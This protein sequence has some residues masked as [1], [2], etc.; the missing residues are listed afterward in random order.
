MCVSQEPIE[1]ASFSKTRARGPEYN[2]SQ[3]KRY[4][5]PAVPFDLSEGF[6]TFRD[7]DRGN[8][9]PADVTPIFESLR[10]AGGGRDEQELAAVDVV[11]WRGNFAKLLATPWNTRDAW[12][13]EA[14]L[15]HG[16]VVLNVVEPE[17]NL[18]RE[19]NREGREA[20]MC[21]WGF[22]FEEACTGGTF[23]NPVD[24]LDS[25]CTVVRTGVGRHRLVMGGEVDC[26]DGEREG[27]GGY[28]ELKTTRVLDSAPQVARFERDKLLKW[29]AQSFSTGVRRILVGFRDDNGTV[30]KL[31][32][33]ETLKLPGYA[34]RHP[35][36]WD[37][38]TA[39]Q[40]TDRLLTWLRTHL[41]SLPMGSRVRMEYEPRRW[42]GEVRIVAFPAGPDGVPAADVPGGVRNFL[43]P[44][45]RASLARAAALRA[46]GGG[47]SSGGAGGSRGS[48]GGSVGNRSG[49][50]T[51]GGTASAAAAAQEAHKKV[52]F[53][54]G[55]GT[56]SGRSERSANPLGLASPAAAAGKNQ[57]ASTGGPDS[58]DIPGSFGRP[59]M[60]PV[61][62]PNVERMVHWDFGEP[63]PPHGHRRRRRHERSQTPV[64]GARSLERGQ[65]LLQVYHPIVA[66]PGYGDPLKMAAYKAAYAHSL[67]PA[68]LSYL[69]GFSPGDD[70]WLGGADEPGEP[71]DEGKENGATQAAKQDYG[72]DPR[73]F[74]FDPLNPA[75]TPK[76]VDLLSG[77]SGD[78]GQQSSWVSAGV[79]P[80]VSAG[81][82]TH[83]GGGSRA[84]DGRS[85][86]RSR[87]GETRSRQRWSTERTTGGGNK[88][89][90]ADTSGGAHSQPSPADIL[91]NSG[92][93]SG[94]VLSDAE[95]GG[96]GGEG[97]LGSKHHGGH[98]AAHDGGPSGSGEKS[99]GE[100]G[101]P[102][103][104]RW[105]AGG[106][107]GGLNSTEGAAGSTG[108]WALGGG[109]DSTEGPGVERRC[110]PRVEQGEKSPMAEEVENGGES[111][112][113]KRDADHE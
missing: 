36:S 7:R 38:K 84:G 112:K 1:L 104:R 105:A 6:E 37:P 25:F 110:N 61:P 49:K 21:Y 95:A 18:R 72:L 86:G 64:P 9:H 54:T 78:G 52:A 107:G 82:P 88:S 92:R 99:S 113:R 40:F 75:A 93:G 26:W 89:N 14:E 67:G 108:G 28:I 76:A 85:D 60:P 15:V 97:A 8:P 70:G 19:A 33:L 24:C 80:E 66:G 100:R 42:R 34:A 111:N 13:M 3:L 56:R 17:D 10:R 32:T 39:L 29:W 98:D 102:S 109:E 16:V 91:S 59:S 101:E 35:N 94:D 48:E 30:V 81:G 11:T 31:Q 65:Q 68:A 63:R 46:A 106:S 22:S 83:S 55:G 53:A 69:Y 58:G 62:S 90:G 41:E 4:L 27:L 77:G 74:A 5:R 47:A 2:K 79:E 51:E 23:A 73:A 57:A 44:E 71:K 20:L 50:P 45:A 87:S 12:H 43:S 96:E 103:G